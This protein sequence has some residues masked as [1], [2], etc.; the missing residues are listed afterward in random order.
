MKTVL[1]TLPL[2]LAACGSAQ[3]GDSKPESGPQESG[4]RWTTP[5]GWV[6]ETVT[7]TMRAKQ[8]SLPGVDGSEDALCVIAHWP[9]GI[10][11]IENNLDRWVSQV[12]PPGS[13]LKARD[14][15]AEQ[16][17][18]LEPKGYVVTNVHVE[19]AI[20]P[21]EGMASD[22]APTDAGAILAGFIEVDGSAEV[23]TVKVT[24]PAST[25]KAHKDRYVQFV[26]GI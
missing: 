6:E 20:Q 24:G 26:S 22:I 12:S 9:G 2:L 8:F 5:D 1:L 23:W 7:Q 4:P 3:S 17:W 21:M 15:T 14:L 16:R 13:T 11:P 19:G 10:G 18:V 25:V